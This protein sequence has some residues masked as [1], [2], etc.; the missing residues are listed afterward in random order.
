MI[1]VAFDAIARLAIAKG[2]A[3]INEHPGCWE[4]RFKHQD[5][6]WFVAVN[7]HRETQECS[8]GAKVEF[9]NAYVTYNGWPA[10]VITPMSGVTV[11]SEIANE[12]ALIEALEIAIEEAELGLRKRG[13]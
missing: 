5:S 13:E 9:G 3:P 1:S 4:A 12:D 7:P 6:E 2:E 8:T 11:A 10:G